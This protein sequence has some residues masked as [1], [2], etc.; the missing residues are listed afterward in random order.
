MSPRPSIREPRLGRASNKGLSSMFTRVKHERWN[1]GNTML[2]SPCRL[3]HIRPPY[4]RRAN[5][6][7]SN[8]IWVRCG[9]QPK[10]RTTS[11]PGRPDR[12]RNRRYADGA[13][14]KVGFLR[15]CDHAQAVERSQ[16]VR[17]AAAR[18]INEVAMSR[19]VVTRGGTILY[20]FAKR[21][22]LF[23]NKV[24]HTAT[25]VFSAGKTSC[26]HG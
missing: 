15:M 20:A 1:G 13:A 24:D 4:P 25:M 5:G 2:K 8:A 23:P 22:Y 9:R 18:S 16:R 6:T 19:D 14:S 26:W 12:E 11:R 3:A 21:Q 17:G 7:T 10:S